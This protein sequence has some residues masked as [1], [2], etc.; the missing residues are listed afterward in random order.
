MRLP[1]CY[2]CCSA[3]LMNE[4]AV[5]EWLSGR[6]NWARLPNLAKAPTGRMWD[7]SW[8]SV[9]AV[10]HCAMLRLGRKLVG[11]GRGDLGNES[12]CVANV[13]F[14]A[15]RHPRSLLPLPGIPLTCGNEFTLG[16]FLLS[17]RTANG[18]RHCDKRLS[19]KATK[20]IAKLKAVAV[21]S[22][23][24]FLFFISGKCVMI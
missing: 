15:E 18:F 20:N 8:H 11:G 17:G 21:A 6:E 24:S 23:L 22:I 7:C 16:T 2:C 19:I 9:L 4:P 1:L 5:N 10:A 12:I 13:W 14:T 3:D